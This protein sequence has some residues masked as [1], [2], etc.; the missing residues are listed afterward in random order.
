MRT[1]L[2]SAPSPDPSCVAL[3]PD[4]RSLPIRRSPVPSLRP[5]NPAAR[6]LSWLM[7]DAVPPRPR[8]PAVIRPAP[9]PWSEMMQARKNGERR[10]W[11][12]SPLYVSHHPGPLLLAPRSQ[13]PPL[14]RLIA[15]IGAESEP[16]LEPP[17][18]RGS[19]NGTLQAFASSEDGYRSV[20]R[21]HP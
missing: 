2:R 15:C 18:H 3:A 8:I 4:R 6:R 10:S 9:V 7:L 20:W 5:P 16:E 17:L 19:L 12:R 11:E 21:R 13:N 14:P 1:C